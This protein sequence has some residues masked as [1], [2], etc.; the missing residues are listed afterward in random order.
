VESTIQGMKKLINYY[1]DKRNIPASS[2]R[3][4]Q[5]HMTSIDHFIKVESYNKAVK[6]ITGMKQLVEKYQEDGHM[7]KKAANT[8]ICHATILIEKWQ[9]TDTHFSM[10]F[11]FIGGQ[12]LIPFHAC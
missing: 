3:M 5:T 11:H 9:Y 1:T 8:L 12:P 10:C 6:H 4:Q 2:V 7:D